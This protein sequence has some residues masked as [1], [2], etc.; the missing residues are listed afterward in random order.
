M[1]SRRG[2][3]RSVDIRR[4]KRHAATDA[5]RSSLKDILADLD[6]GRLTVEQAM[7]ALN[8]LE[9]SRTTPVERFFNALVA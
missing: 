9:K 2:S 3:T 8:E 7:E 6:G 5:N 4:G 1:T